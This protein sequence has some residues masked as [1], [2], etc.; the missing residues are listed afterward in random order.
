MG[1]ATV[2]RYLA[3]LPLP[4]A[5]VDLTGVTSIRWMIWI[6]MRKNGPPSCARRYHCL[7]RRTVARELTDMTLSI[8]VYRS[9][10]L[11]LCAVPL[12]SRELRFIAVA[13]ELVAKVT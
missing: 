13:I 7:Q 10:L 4:I 3:I 12:E 8:V 11:L 1:G 9:S 5:R 6:L 2:P